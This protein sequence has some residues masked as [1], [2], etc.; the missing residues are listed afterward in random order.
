MAE[1]P[2]VYDDGEKIEKMNKVYRKDAMVED[3]KILS[4]I[5]E[6]NDITI[7]YDSNKCIIKAGEFKYVSKPYIIGFNEDRKKEEKE[8]EINVEKD[9]NGI[10]KKLKIKCTCGREINI[11]LE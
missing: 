8:P 6:T 10:V 1:Q 2:P 5:N 9:S 3:D 7:N 11:D 4:G